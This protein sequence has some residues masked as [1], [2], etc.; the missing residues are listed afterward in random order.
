MKRQRLFELFLALWL[1][2]Y[3]RLV[4][5]A[6]SLTQGLATYDWNSLGIVAAVGIAG[7]CSQ[8][9]YALGSKR[10]VV[11]DV[12]FVLLRDAM[13]GMGS[14]LLV[15]F[16]IN[17]NNA[18]AEIGATLPW[19]GIKMMQMPRDVVVLSVFLAGISSGWILFF[20]RD[21]LTT[22]ALAIRRYVFK[23][24]SPFPMT[25]TVALDEK[26]P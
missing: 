17:V 4:Y 16:L 10:I 19:V 6:T 7:G 1:V 15:F 8:T 13:L 3:C 2:A 11:A 20:A 12:A 25:D 24:A 26:T 23:R 14:T 5:A 9:L 21:T 18:Y 22:L